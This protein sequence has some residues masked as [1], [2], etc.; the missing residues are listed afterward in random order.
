MKFRIYHQEFN[1]DVDY[2]TIE[3]DTL[4]EC[5]DRAHYECGKRGWKDVDCWSEQ[6]EG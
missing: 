4:K 3:G 1:G 2:L 6:E 5:I